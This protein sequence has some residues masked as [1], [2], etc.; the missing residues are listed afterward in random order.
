MCDQKPSDDLTCIHAERGLCPDCQE[1]FDEDP[2][3][4]FE[5]GQHAA[6]LEN[7]RRLEAEM[8]EERLAEEE[9][10]PLPTCGDDEIPF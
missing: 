10:K 4:W 5:F 3:A 7:W 2:A 8:E 1:E 6:G 9:S